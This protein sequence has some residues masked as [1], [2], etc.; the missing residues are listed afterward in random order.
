MSYTAVGDGVNLASRLEG[1]NKQYG[2]SILVS[3]STYKAAGDPFCFRL[4]DVVAVKGKT[5]GVRIYELRGEASQPDP[6]SDVI[7]P[8]SDPSRPMFPA[9]SPGPPRFSCLR[10]RLI[11]QVRSCF[12]AAEPTCKTHRQLA[13]TAS[14]SRRRNDAQECRQCGSLGFRCAR[15]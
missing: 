2:T 15:I 12:P 8:M 5:Q 7:P 14:M 9:S 3:E 11:R 10:A 1:L 13:G 4:L 6:Q